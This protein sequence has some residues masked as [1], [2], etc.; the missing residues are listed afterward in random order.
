M[1]L[2]LQDRIL[3]FASAM[4][5]GR[6][7]GLLWVPPG[8]ALEAGEDWTTAAAR[9]LREETGFT[10]PIGPCVWIREHTWFWAERNAWIRSVEH[11]FVARTDV[12]AIATDDW[13]DP[14]RRVITDWRWWSAEELRHTA[15]TLVPRR[16]GHLVHDLVAGLPA[17]PLHIAE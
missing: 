10:V 3:L 2:D 9:E 15:D 11:F 13:T 8:G 4:P 1:L 16:L 7:P 6:S 5:D 12:T 14:E 17:T